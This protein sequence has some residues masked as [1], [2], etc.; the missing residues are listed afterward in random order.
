M[1]VFMRNDCDEF[2]GSNCDFSGLV[3]QPLN[4]SEGAAGM[5]IRQCYND[6][7]DESDT[8]LPP[9]DQQ[10]KICHHPARDPMMAHCCGKIFC[11]EC[12]IKHLEDSQDD[13]NM[14]C[15]YCEEEDFACVPLHVRC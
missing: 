10:C 5:R 14:P 8:A 9:D 15:P 4:G 1:A 13:Q 3:R 6:T 12:L 2:D 11:S 7:L